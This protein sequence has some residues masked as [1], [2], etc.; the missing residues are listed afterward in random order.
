MKGY[1]QIDAFLHSLVGRISFQQ[2]PNRKT[3][4]ERKVLQTAHLY[5]SSTF[6]EN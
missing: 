6:C 3:K 5:K 2:R 1:E 4:Y